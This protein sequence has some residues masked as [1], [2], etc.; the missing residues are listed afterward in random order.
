MTEASPR[1]KPSFPALYSLAFLLAAALSFVMLAT[2]KNLRTDFGTVP[3]GY[4]VHWYAVLVM[5]VVDLLGAA[6]LLVLR[7]RTAV[8]LGVV[9]SALLTIANLAVIATYSQ[10]GF[11]SA[12]D[13]AQYLF[14]VTYFGGDLR[15]LYD[16]LLATYIGTFAL[17]V[18]GLAITRNSP[19]PATASPSDSRPTA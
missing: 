9:G 2:D 1:S 10:V 8:K 14:G 11:A 5:G 17:G 18:V 15:Y 12:S 16:L 13:F 3:T 19:K 4:F 6:L 7:S